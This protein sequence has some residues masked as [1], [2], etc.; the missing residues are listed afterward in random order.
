MRHIIY[1][2]II[3]L[4]LSS[5]VLS[6]AGSQKNITVMIK[7]DRDLSDV[8][9]TE[10]EIFGCNSKYENCKSLQKIQPTFLGLHYINVPSHSSYQFETT[11]LNCSHGAFT[12]IGGH[13][14]PDENVYTVKVEKYCN[15][16]STI[17]VNGFER[18]LKN[19]ETPENWGRTILGPENG[20]KEK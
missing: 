5:C 15:E 4:F 3:C 7:S 20:P 11:T 14:R 9:N 2:A 12:S 17:E 16:V 10:I 8:K 6:N 19:T 18:Q 1:T 13:V